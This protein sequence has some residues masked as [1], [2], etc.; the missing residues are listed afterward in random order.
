MYLEAAQCIPFNLSVLNVAFVRLLDMSLGTT[1]NSF[2]LCKRQE[3]ILRCSIGHESTESHKLL[4]LIVHDRTTQKQKLTLH[5]S[6]CRSE[7]LTKRWKDNVLR[8][9]KASAKVTSLAILRGCLNLTAMRSYLNKLLLNWQSNQEMY[10]STWKLHWK[11]Y[12]PR[13]NMFRKHS[14]IG[15]SQ[16]FSKVYGTI[17]YELCISRCRNTRL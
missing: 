6:M 9:L 1:K 8:F 14:G 12:W 7:T 17:L 2:R 5:L 13:K 15:W 3:S 16:Q 10:N 11:V 4:H